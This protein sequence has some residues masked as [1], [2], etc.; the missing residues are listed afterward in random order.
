MQKLLCFCCE[1]STHIEG[2]LF[3]VPTLPIC[4]ICRDMSLSFIKS[5]EIPMTTEHL[6]IRE[7]VE[8]TRL[9]GRG[10]WRFYNSLTREGDLVFRLEKKV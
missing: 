6:L 10:F 3:G 5:C 7:L 4:R 2:L 1:E 9:D 8:N